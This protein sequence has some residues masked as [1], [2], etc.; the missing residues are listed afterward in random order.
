[1]NIIILQEYCVIY[2]Q[3]LN[4]GFKCR[5][6]HYK[7]KAQTP[8][9]SNKKPGNASKLNLVIYISTYKGIHKFQTPKGPAVSE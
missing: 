1:M 7:I 6:D 8:S 3:F 5:R 2:K 9:N 4:M